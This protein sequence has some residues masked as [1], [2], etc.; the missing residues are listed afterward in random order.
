MGGK[1][2]REAGAELIVDSSR[3][4]A[5]GLAAGLSMIP[6]VLS[7]R[8]RVHA[9]LLRRRPDVLVVIDAGAFH[10][11]FGP[12]EGLC[13]WVRRKLPKTKILYYFPPGSW[14]RTL[15]ETSLNGAADAVVTP[16]PW[17]ETELRRL[18]VDASF[19]GHPL[20]DLA[21]PSMSVEAFAERFGIDRDRPI[22]GLLPGSRAQEIEHILPALVGAAARIH[23][24]VPG[25]QF[26]LALAPTVDR[27]QVETIVVAERRRAVAALSVSA[28]G[29]EMPSVPEPVA[30]VVPVPVGAGLD[31]PA[32]QSAW[33]ERAGGPPGDGNFPLA[34]VED[35]AY[36]VM[37]ASDILLCAS[38]TATLEATLLARPMVIVYRGATGGLGLEY[39]LIR[40]RLPE[41]V[42]MPNL[43]AQRRIC[44]ELIQEEATP[45][46]IAGEA[47][48][49][50]LDPDRIGRMREDLREVVAQLGTP[51]AAER[52]ARR[53]L[54]LGS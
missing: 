52:T 39:R 16:F 50:L 13:F 18:G 10:L 29:S 3:F 54:E 24:R 51:G 8:R 27:A 26:L 37:A 40:S 41:F 46:A 53:V 47:I 49:L 23:Q 15:R 7:A 43:L 22:V 30:G 12:I 2:L 35:A 4:G 20:L 33:I 38:G 45:E 21:R 1:Y 11:G 32:R 42:G 28:A 44:T 17:S 6:R 5:I 34:I 36:D 48:G 31:D 9:E 25:V 14:R 19:Y